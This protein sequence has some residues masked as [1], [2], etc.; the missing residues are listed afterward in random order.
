MR[1]LRIADP[2]FEERTHSPLANCL[3]H[4]NTETDLP[5]APPSRQQSVDW[6]EKWSAG[7]G[8]ISEKLAL[9]AAELDR[10]AAVGPEQPV[11]SVFDSEA[12]SY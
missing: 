7:N 9:I 11:L 1:N 6:Q 4:L 3:I 10:L 8:Q 5:P 12:D 2:D